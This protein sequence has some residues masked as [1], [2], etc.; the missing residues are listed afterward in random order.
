[1]VL[2]P[3][4][5]AAAPFVAMIT[6]ECIEVGLT[7]L[8]KAAMKQGMSNFVFIV[9]YNALGT[10]IL[11]PLFLYNTFRGK[12]V[13][14]TFS[15]LY[16]FFLLGLIGIC[17]LQ[18]C[19]YTGI[20]YSSPTLAAAIGN[21]IPVFTFI[22]AVILGLEKLNIRNSS[23]QAKCLGTIIAI[24][25]AMVATLYKGPP[26][27]IAPTSSIS[28][29]KLLVQFSNWALGGLL[30]VITCVLSSTANILQ[31]Y[32]AKEC[33]D[34]V[35]LVFFYSFFGTMLSAAFSVF[36]ERDPDA[37]KPHNRIE[38]VAILYAAVTT[39]VFRNTVIT[40]CLRERGPVY[41][42]I[43]KPLSIVVAMIM[44]LIFLGDNLYLGSVIG[45][46][47]IATGFYAVIWGQAREKETVCNLENTYDQ[48]TPLL[49]STDGRS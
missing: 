31:A 30:L 14:I 8:S 19:A 16:K 6:V 23:S 48:N 35:V 36:L 7:T 5:R 13:P 28:P 24:S 43:Y 12:K 18:I 20:N 44:G 46:A 47:A 26:V 4:L 49:N 10:L 40:W 17:L 1:M 37:W 25:G 3:C 9:Y 29:N 41:V 15:L 45:S 39:T 2:N 27:V 11:L 38:I 33:P 32:A 42:T 22:F 21:L 34:E